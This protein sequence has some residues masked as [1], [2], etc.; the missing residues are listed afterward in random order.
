MC[1]IRKKKMGETEVKKT[2][3]ETQRYNTLHWAFSGPGEPSGLGC[4]VCVSGKARS[5]RWG[6]VM[7]D[8]RGKPQL[9]GG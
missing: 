1:L 6:M 8:G 2:C 3:T 5:G 4:R 9:L 7:K